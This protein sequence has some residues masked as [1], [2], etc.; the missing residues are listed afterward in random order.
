MRESAAESA[1]TSASPRAISV[2]FT[3][4]SAAASLSFFSAANRALETPAISSRATAG[5]SHAAVIRDM[6]ILSPVFGRS[7]LRKFLG[8]RDDDARRAPHVA[9]SVLVLVLGH[10]ADE[11]G[12]VGA[13][14]SDGV[15]DALDGEHDAP[16]AE[17]VRRGDGWFDL[18][19]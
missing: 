5:R 18:D 9:E 3:S 10:L 6:T 14:A 17:R 11:F 4:S 12:A 2:A 16:Q 15:V 13:Q 19:Q 1:L 8:Q 7:T